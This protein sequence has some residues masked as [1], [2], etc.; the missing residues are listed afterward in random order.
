[1]M[2]PW[3]ED[4][5]TYGFHD[6]D[7]VTS[8]RYL[9]KTSLLK[10]G[11]LP[12]WNAYACGGYPSW[13]YVEGATN[14]VSPWLPAYLLLPLPLALRVEVA[15]MALLGAFGAYALGSCFT[16]SQAARLLVA[17]L[18]A[19]NGRWGLQTAS[20]HAWHLAYALL[21]W[22]FFFFERARGADGKLRDLAL[23]G[24]A[25]AWLVY[26]GGIYPLP[27]TVLA[28]GCYAALLA[29]QRRDLQPLGILA[30]GGLIGVGLA[31]P[32]LLP[33]LDTFAADPRLIESK[34]RLD[35]GALV[36]LLTHPQ[37]PFRSRPA[38][39]RPY[40]W[41]EWG[42]YIS[43]AGLGILAVGVALVGGRRERVLKVVG[44]LF[45]V[46]GLGAF[47][48]QAPWSLLH[49]H[50]P[51]FRSQHVP[52]RFLYPAVLLLALVAAAGLGRLVERRR[53]LP[54]LDA[55]LAA[56]V[57]LLAVDVA[58][59]AQQP[60][61]DA[62]WMVPPDI[63]PDGSFHFEEQP[64][65]HYRKRD[66]A[67]PML[68]SMMANTGVLN[69]YG[70]PRKEGQKPA[71]IARGAPGYRGEVYVEGGGEAEILH[72]SPS[73]VQVQVHGAQ[74]AEGL[75]GRVPDVGELF[76]EEHP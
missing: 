24:G 64:P 36:T 40:G 49:Q 29:L 15:G 57:C 65:Y 48:A 42:M 67:G 10:H 17:A 14:L 12:W 35:L 60:M 62:M 53:R 2:A 44:L 45:A 70:V 33:M 27:H 41:H 26:A 59:V 9:T 7:V 20:G 68:L 28:L 51:V 63:P 32:K 38:P 76:F 4:V 54:W 11:Q 47:H 61:R 75:R 19:V 52:S 73:Q 30:L 72:W 43:W 69:C 56:L 13:G 46:L 58:R 74:P 23:L 1:V 5:T 66:W 39:V 25:F 16:R 8:F 18:W 21:P 50:L 31:A 22:C 3:F 37:Q 71:A 6:W 34:E 55:A